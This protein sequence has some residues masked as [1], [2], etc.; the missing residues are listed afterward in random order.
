LIGGLL[1]YQVLD[2]LVAARATDTRNAVCLSDDPLDL[3]CARNLGITA[4]F[5]AYGRL[6]SGVYRGDQFG[7]VLSPEQVPRR[8]GCRS[9]RA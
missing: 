1:P 9:R 2:E 8:L 4:L 5:A 6:T 7:V 3:E